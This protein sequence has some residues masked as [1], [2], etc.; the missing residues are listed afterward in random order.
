M[1][2]RYPI[3]IQ[4]INKTE[5]SQKQDL[6]AV[7]EPLEI[8]MRWQKNGETNQKSISITMRT[9]G[10]DEDLALG[11]LLTEG[12]IQRMDQIAS[13]GRPAFPVTTE[14]NRILVE[15]V[16][17]VEMDISKLERHFYTS[18]S[19]GVCGK[20]SIDAI[21]ATGIQPLNPTQFLVNDQLIH[22]LPEKLRQQQ[23]VF[24]DTGG[25]HA[26][27]L[28]DNKGKLQL[29][30]EDVGRHNAVDKLIGAALQ[31]DKLPLSDSLI[32]VSGR[33]S[34]ELIQKA[35]MAGIPI[36]AAVGAPSSLAVQ[37]AEKSGMTVLG[38]VRSGRYNIY[39]HPQRVLNL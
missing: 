27:A 4:H 38:F 19:C 14:E 18:S 5:R 17:D 13:V 31:N 8:Q 6:L 11:F 2:S 23:S 3:E 24:E 33:A 21:Y 28:F 25:L 9:P 34:F 12:I 15:L 22:Q 16:S 36:L 26:A 32:L 1:S 30:R 37:L 20:S 35:L 29:L 7:E 10:N 39:C